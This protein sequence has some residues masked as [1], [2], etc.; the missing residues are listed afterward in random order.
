MN[1]ASA[2]GQERP[3]AKMSGRDIR[4][5]CRSGVFDRPTAGVALGYAQA[6]LVSLNRDLAEDFETF[7]RS[8]PKPC[9]LLEVLAP[10]AYE[11]SLLARGADV[12]TDLPRYRVYREGVCVSRPTEI[13]QVWRDDLVTF[14]IGCSFTF[15][16]ALIQAR[17]PV[18]HIEEGRNVPMYRTNISC[19][20]AGPFA[21][22]LIVSMRPMSREQA[23][24]AVR[25]TKAHERVHGSPVQ[26]GDA[27]AIGITDLDQPDYGDAVTIL[28]GEIPVFWACGVTPM[29]AVMRAGAELAVTHDPGHM[30]VTDL[31]DESLLQR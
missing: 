23:A 30:F 16:S 15:E 19:R 12:R 4:M 26:V 10:G 3:F 31:L 9:P 17:L 21:G 14:L 22:P 13:R 25:L 5:L 29:E 11:P 20:P 6:N 2:T 24:E 27:E 28:P 1:G 7:C 8:N 18:R